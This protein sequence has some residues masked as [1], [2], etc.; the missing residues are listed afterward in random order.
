MRIIRNLN[1][2][3]ELSVSTPEIRTEMKE[4][5]EN[6]GIIPGV[7]RVEDLQTRAWLGIV[8]ILAG[9]LFL[10][11]TYIENCI[12]YIFCME[13]KKVTEHSA[14]VAILQRGNE[15]NVTTILLHEVLMDDQ[16]KCKNSSSRAKHYTSQNGIT[17]SFCN[18]KM[19]HYDKRIDSDNQ[20]L[21]SSI[22]SLTYA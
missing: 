17:G 9:K 6:Q 10:G 3:V 14:P 20:T 11:T 5:I 8:Q 4:M 16:K 19:C 2:N 12:Q 13:H 7:V 22:F 1:R 15:A 18:V 21:K